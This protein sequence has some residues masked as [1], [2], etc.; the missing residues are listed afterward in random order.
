M[1]VL[2]SDSDNL[3]LA[4]KVGIRTMLE[5][6]YPSVVFLSVGIVCV[7]SAMLWHQMWHLILGEPAPPSEVI[8]SLVTYAFVYTVFWIIAVLLIFSGV[9]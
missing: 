5:F 9:L 8:N 6:V 7:S 2:P 3:E 1:T 4:E